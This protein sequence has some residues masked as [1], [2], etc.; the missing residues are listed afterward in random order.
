MSTWQTHAAILAGG[1]GVLLWPV[2]RSMLRRRRRM[3]D[4]PA[5]PDAPLETHVSV[6]GLL[7]AVVFEATGK[8]LRVQVY[9]KQDDGLYGQPWIPISTSFADREALP[10]VLRDSLHGNYT[11]RE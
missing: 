9:A 3:A 7:K 10:G 11:D 1:L 2:V 6:D 8:C 4:L 5:L